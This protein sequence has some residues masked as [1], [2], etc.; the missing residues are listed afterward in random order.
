V[1]SFV[2]HR[3]GEF[4]SDT[5]KGSTRL[6]GDRSAI[7]KCRKNEGREKWFGGAQEGRR[8][9]GEEGRSDLTRISSET[10]WTSHFDF[11]TFRSSFQSR[12][13]TFSIQQGMGAANLDSAEQDM[14]PSSNP[15]ASLF[16]VN[17]CVLSKVAEQGRTQSVR[18]S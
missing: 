7:Q 17:F 12:A 2:S 5:S 8:A 15:S 10:A 13:S 4:D 3:G 1:G 18:L 11:R 6:E 16:P 9:G 14:K